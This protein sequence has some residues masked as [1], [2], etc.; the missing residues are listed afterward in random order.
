MS[1]DLKRVDGPYSSPMSDGEGPGDQPEQYR[2]LS[3]AAVSA[4]VFGVLA[5]TA[6]F[7]YWLVVVPLVGVAWGLIALKQIRA[8]P[9]ELTG[10]SLAMVGLALS[11]VLLFAGPAWVYYDEMRQVPPGYQLISYDDL[12]PNPNVFGEVVPKSATDLNGKK[13]YIKGFVLA[14]SRLDGISE[15]MLVRDAGTCCFGG[16]PKTTDKI[17][18]KVA[19]Q[20]GAVYMKQMARVSGVF[21]VA[22][23][24]G[25]SGEVLA[26]YHLD[27]AE[28]R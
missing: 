21:R 2:A 6:L 20:G 25:P 22:P 13:V 18:V 14:G 15:F 27:H 23:A 16:N 19:T 12:Q 11:C 17:A 26:Y 28:L 5:L 9:A 4:L 7:D 10:R 8:R 1:V 24:L 3:S